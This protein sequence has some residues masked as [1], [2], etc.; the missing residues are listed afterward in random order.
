VLSRLHARLRPEIEELEAM[1]R[2]DFSGWK[3][4]KTA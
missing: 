3:L 2:R 1:V 4:G